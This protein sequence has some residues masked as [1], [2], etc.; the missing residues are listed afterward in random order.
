MASTS[1]IEAQITA[2]IDLGEESGCIELS[3]VSELVQALDLPDD[4]IDELYERI[5]RK[6]IDLSDNCAR[7]GAVEASYVNT[8]LASTTTDALQLFLSEVG[9][10]ALLT[11]DEEVDLAKRIESGDREATERM[12]NSNLRLVVSIAKRYQG[13]EL[14]LLDLIQEGILGLMRAVE[15]FD[16]RRGFKF[17]TYATWW[18][19]QAIERG[20]ANKARM[21]RMPVHISQ[22]ERKI[23]RVQQQ[24][25]VQLGRQPN[26][27]EIANAAKLSVKQV[28]E[29]H[30]AARSVTSLDLPVGE[31][32]SMV[33]GDVFISDEA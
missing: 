30:D 10:H 1:S 21:I 9:K 5:S 19:R 13:R 22:R 8:E 28:R 6:G 29:V 31:D 2:L 4:Q 7:E 24:L 26:D 33:L 20:L 23:V 25:S 3:E 12:I 14:M 27:E 16:W 32:E 18:I 17:S 15:K 11:A